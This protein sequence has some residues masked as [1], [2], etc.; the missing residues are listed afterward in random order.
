MDTSEFYH[1]SSGGSLEKIKVA[2]AYGA[3][4]VYCAGSRFGLRARA[5]NLTLPELHE[6]IEYTHSHG[7]KLYLTLNI[8][9]HNRDIEAM[10]ADLKELR[11]LALDAVI[12]SDPGVLSLVRTELPDIPIHLSTQMNTTNYLSARFARSGAKALAIL[13]LDFIL[14]IGRDLFK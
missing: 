14:T 2:V 9:A 13:S 8:F 5:K 3:D 4:A 7:A 12:V 6:A 10:R 1:I 11:G